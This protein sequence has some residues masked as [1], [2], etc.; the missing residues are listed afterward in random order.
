MKPAIQPTPTGESPR[1]AARGTIALVVGAGAGVVLAAA[2]LLAPGAALRSGVPEGVAASVNGEPIRTE[3]YERAVAAVAAD[4]RSELS[5]ADRRQILERL[6]EEELLVQ[7]GLE[8]GLARRD[9]QVRADLTRAIIASVLATEAGTETT[10]DEVVSFYRQHRELFARP[11]R[12]RVRQ[13]FVRVPAAK[14]EAD[15]RERAAEA[16][17][18]LRAGER[19][20]EVRER[21]GDGELASIPDA[22]L[23]AEKLLDYLGPTVVRA[24]LPLDPGGVSDPV[25]SGSGFHVLQVVE[26]TAPSVPPLEEVRAEVAAELRR[27]SG[28]R[29]LRDYL[30]RLRRSADVEIARELR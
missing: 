18:R 9:S 30:D 2:G 8:L 5:A 20:D 15:S 11:G 22:P 16:A 6:I 28:D 17:R 13:V 4:R 10:E 21:L 26:R 24:L 14:D 27:R 23:P 12:M 3:S 7:R 25:R 1:S 19:F 29:A